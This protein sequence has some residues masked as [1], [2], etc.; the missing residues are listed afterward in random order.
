MTEEGVKVGQKQRD[1]VY[2]QS[3]ITVIT[4][5]I[6][7]KYNACAISDRHLKV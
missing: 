5:T 7:T 6:T 3:S 4:V 1:V 2:G